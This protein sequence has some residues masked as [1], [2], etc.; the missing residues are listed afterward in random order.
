MFFSIRAR[1]CDRGRRNPLYESVQATTAI[2]S[3]MSPVT[4]LQA[5]QLLRLEFRVHD[6]FLSSLSSFS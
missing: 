6:P 3:S 4:V 5:S 1:I 2:C